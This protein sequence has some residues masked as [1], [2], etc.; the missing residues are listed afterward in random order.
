MTKFSG[1]KIG[2]VLQRSEA[3]EAT[4]GLNGGL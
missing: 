2:Q 3:N 1:K 4:N